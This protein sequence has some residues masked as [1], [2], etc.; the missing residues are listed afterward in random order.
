MFHR[1]SERK[2]A[3]FS[4][5]FLHMPEVYFRQCVA[6]SKI[7][8]KMRKEIPGFAAALLAGGASSRMQRD[9]VLMPV[10]F[11]NTRVALWQRQWMILAALN[12]AEIIISGPR[13][14][15]YPSSISV[16]PDRWPRIGPLSGL[17][18]C[19]EWT[20]SQFLLALAVDMAQISEACL[21][22]LLQ[23]VTYGCGVIPIQRQRYEPLAAIYPR[24]AL[25]AMT[26]FLRN[27]GRRLQELSQVLVD[28]KLVKCWPIPPALTSEFSNWNRTEDVC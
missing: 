20:K 25:P 19:L 4:Q 6:C 13:K 28:E 12:P 22:I 11:E 15:A 16:I 23:Q 5:R 26:E 18:T 17:A 1:S 9:K 21:R 8:S 24:A 3:L 27:G 14:D 10:V 7:F 2:V